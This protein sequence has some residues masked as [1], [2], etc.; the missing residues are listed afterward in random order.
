M[1]EFAA[2]VAGG[3]RLDW[4]VGLRMGCVREGKKW[5]MY[6]KIR[7]ERAD[8]GGKLIVRAGNGVSAFRPDFKSIG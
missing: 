1:V 4:S 3:P 2:K 5:L 6:T 7:A 8:G